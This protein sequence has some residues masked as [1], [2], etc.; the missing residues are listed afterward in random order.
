MTEMFMNIL[1]FHNI[2]FEYDFGK[3]YYAFTFGWMDNGMVIIENDYRI[4][5]FNSTFNTR[6]NELKY[7]KFEDVVDMVLELYSEYTE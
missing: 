4:G 7:Y 3:G 1:E 6:W 5:F 2:P